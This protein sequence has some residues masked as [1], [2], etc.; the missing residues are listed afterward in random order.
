MPTAESLHGCASLLARRTN[1]R[2][3]AEGSSG[4][5]LAEQRMDVMMVSEVRRF[6]V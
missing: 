1:T 5:T 2:E 3:D 6:S 4:R